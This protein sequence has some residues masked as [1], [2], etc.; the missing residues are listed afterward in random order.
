MN[1]LLKRCLI[2]AA[3][4]GAVLT[5]Q[6]QEPAPDL[7]KSSDIKAAIEAAEAND[8]LAE[9]ARKQLLDTYRR[10]QSFLS[11]REEHK[12]RTA[13][14]RA[15]LENASAEAGRISDQLEKDMAAYEGKEPAPPP[16]MERSQAEAALQTARSDLA[17]AEARSAQITASINAESGRAD[18]IRAETVESQQLRDTLRESVAVVDGVNPVTATAQKWLNATQIAALTAEIAMLEQELLSRPARL[19]LLNAQQERVAFDVLR[20]R[21]RVKMLDQLVV[22][23]KQQEAQQVLTEVAEAQEAAADAHPKIQELAQANTVLTAEITAS[24][25][26]L[27]QIKARDSAASDL[28]QRY[29]SDLDNIQRKLKVLGMSEALGRVLREQQVRLPRALYSRADVARRDALISDSSLRQLVY[30]DERRKLRSLSTYVA[31]L[32][33]DLPPQEAEEINEDMMSL[34]RTRRELIDRAIDTEGSYLRALGDLDFEIRRVQTA[35]AAYREFISE[36]LLWIRSTSPYSLD[37][38]KVIPGEL[39]LL[40]SPTHWWNI[41]RLLPNAILSSAWYPLALLLVLVLLR[42][43]GR[44]LEQLERSSENVGRV[45]EDNF[46]KTVQALLLTFAIALTWPLLTMTVGIALDNHGHGE[47][48]EK[49]VAYALRSVSAYFFGLE[50]LR[51]LLVPQGIVRGHFK[52]NE[53][54]T[55]RM[56]RKL[57]QFEVVL[58]P[59]MA[60]ATVANRV[61]PVVGQSVVASIGLIVALLAIARFFAMAPSMMQGQLDKLVAMRSGQRRSL[62]GRLFRYAIILLPLALVACTVLGYQHTAAEFTR[63]LIF[64]NGLFAG[65]LLLQE[66]G[67]RWLKIMRL[68][69][70]RSKREAALKAAREAAENPDHDGEIV[71]NFDEPDPHT[72]SDEGRGLLNSVLLVTAILGVWAVWGDVVPALGILNSVELWTSSEIINGVETASPVTPIDIIKVLLVTFVGYMAVQRLPSLLEL[73]LRQKMELAAGTVYAGVTL[74]RYIL[75]G[76]F[77]VLVL[78]MLGA[79]WGSIQWAVA[80]LSVGIGFG[81]QEI[82]ANFISGLILLF[83]QPIRVGDT[84][85]VGETSGVITKIRMRATTVRDWDGRELLVPNKEFITGRLLNWSLS[86]TQTRIVIEIGIAYGSD[87]PKAMKLALDA[88]IEHPDTLEDPE[89]FITFDAFGDNSLLLRLRAYLPN[90]DRRLGI[91]S[92]LREAINDKYKEAGI[93]IAFPQRDVHLNTLAPLEVLLRSDAEAAPS[94]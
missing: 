57:W 51:Y 88:A 94:S 18:Q 54:V 32:T 49:A 90:V 91:S 89:P 78:G 14:Y 35:T 11:K 45:S 67:V 69:M 15:A 17:A 56:F 92:E 82:V 16:G 27:E 60:F 42:Y 77:V 1:L 81:L 59:V 86:D 41:L 8:A 61:T 58:I 74:V 87:V 55:R 25:N 66:L 19:E 4:L 53:D 52:W 65:L 34:A 29:E 24:T 36:R 7:P 44:L 13:N 28:A 62:M 70:V 76:S 33:G 50:F 85:T 26:A 72:L 40:M 3:L 22:S 9:E 37:T 20:L 71:D 80:A 47:R 73:F 84:V 64:T 46:S 48:F 21:S 10:A 12:Q 39:G 30:E 6:A 2:A 5:G 31:E 75:V 23:I 43:H 83:E 63:L 68:R 38:V 79:S 93:V